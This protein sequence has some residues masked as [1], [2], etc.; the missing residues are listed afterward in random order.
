MRADFRFLRQGKDF[1]AHVKSISEAQGY[2]NRGLHTIKR[3]DAN[4][5]IASLSKLDLSSRHLVNGAMLTDSGVLLCEYFE[6]RARVLEDYV[7]HW[8]MSA[9]QAHGLFIE[10]QARLRPT[11]PLV[12]NKQKNEMANPAY[13][14]C[15][16]NMIVENV[17]G[18]HGFNHNPGALTTFTQNAM[19]LRTLSRRVDGALPGVVN[20]VALWEIKEYYYTTSFG[21]RVADG[22][23][24]TL[25][26]GLELEEM[27]EHTG[28]N[29]SHMLAIDAHLTWWIMGR[30]YLCRMIDMLHMGMV[31]DILFGR[32]V[33][34]VLPGLVREWVHIAQ[35]RTRL[36]PQIHGPESTAAIQHPTLI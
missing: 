32:E 18:P 24:E 33:V 25:L 2:V 14:T 9:E 27:R 26:D 19:P 17:A 29:C 21:S 6:Y 30:S 8:L 10:T 35:Q 12:M 15:L 34:E 5:I 16:V 36:E 3:L 28:I 1:W 4:G 31:D 11:L 7:Q 13:L 20:P 23:Y 22:V